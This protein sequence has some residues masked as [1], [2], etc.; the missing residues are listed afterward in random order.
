LTNE[1]EILA[2]MEAHAAARNLAIKR[3]IFNKITHETL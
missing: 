2:A 1:S 3:K